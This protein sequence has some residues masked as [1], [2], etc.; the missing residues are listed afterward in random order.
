MGIPCCICHHRPMEFSRAGWALGLLVAEDLLRSLPRAQGASTQMGSMFVAW[1]CVYTRGNSKLALPA[2]RFKLSYSC[3]EVVL[4]TTCVRDKNKA[5]QARP[6]T[7]VSRDTVHLPSAPLAVFF[8]VQHSRIC[9]LVADVLGEELV[10][11]W[12]KFLTPARPLLV[13]G[14]DIAEGQADL[15]GFHSH[16]LQPPGR[17]RSSLKGEAQHLPQDMLGNFC[18]AFSCYILCIKLYLIILFV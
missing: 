6:Q 18:Y 4:Q 8:R 1:V 10:Q 11:L 17:S 16:T 15:P 2:G 3:S 14:Q 13:P 7:Q 5:L 12:L 9:C